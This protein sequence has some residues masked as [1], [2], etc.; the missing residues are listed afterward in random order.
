[1]PH[2][3]RHAEAYETRIIIHDHSIQTI[4]P[5]YLLH[6]SSTIIQYQKQLR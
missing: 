2:I 6:T 4:I 1:M 3:A 5:R